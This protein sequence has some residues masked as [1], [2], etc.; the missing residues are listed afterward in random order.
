MDRLACVDLPAF[1]LQLL[2]RQ[3]PEWQGQP[4]A[5]V[6]KETPQGEV[7]VTCEKARQLGVLPGLR[8][9][10][11]LGLAPDLRARALDP[12][13]LTRE[14]DALTDQLRRISP[15]VEPMGNT[16]GVFWLNAGG[17]HRLNRSLAEWAKRAR[18]LLKKNGYRATVAVGF[19]RFGTYALARAKQGIVL[20]DSP[21]QERALAR[22]VPLDRLELRPTLRIRLTKLGQRTTGDLLDLPANG[23]LERFGPELYQLHRLAAGEVWHPLQPQPD[24]PELAEQLILD[25]PTDSATA[26][27]FL[28]KRL[29]DPLLK[30]VLAHHQLLTRLE[31]HLS[32][33]HAG[34][35]T[36]EIRPAAPTFDTDQL[37]DLIRLRLES[38]TIEHPVAELKLVATGVPQT[39]EQ[40][41]LFAQHPRRDL[42]AAERAFARLRAEFGPQAV[43]TVKL[44]EGH[45]PEAR[46]TFEPL[47]KFNLPTVEPTAPKRQLIRRLLTKPIPLQPRPVCG[48]RGCHLDGLGTEPITELKGPYLISGGWWMRPVEREYY[49]ATT[50]QQNTLWIYF[51]RQRRRWCIQGE[52]D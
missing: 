34:T 20:L 29:L 21:A 52:V 16:P 11:A 7:L 50:A 43:V 9:A 42:Q 44:K 38:I 28:A 45:L 6:S 1:A 12:L 31:L 49:F 30:K 32:L 36:E 40:L 3:H 23:L 39:T 33:D 47:E 13:V 27:T 41:Q 26:L 46:F 35:H 24:E 4:A 14:V 19:S 8:Y 2:K 10:A 17:F 18:R 48:P 22:R 37:L 25:A 15:D 5:V 51:D